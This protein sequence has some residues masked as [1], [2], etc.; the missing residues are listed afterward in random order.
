[1]S[2]RRNF[3]RRQQQLGG[4]FM[5]V[6]SLGGVV[7][8]WYLAYSKGC[9][10]PKTSVIFPAFLFVGLGLI[11]FPDYRAERTARGEDI[12]ELSGLKLITARWW[13]ILIVGLLAGFANFA[14]LR[15]L[16]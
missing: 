3:T 16:G 2:E 15:F 6:L 4:L 10:Y 9:F 11:L 14:L 1:M 5:S 12:S 8:T 13:L 7:F